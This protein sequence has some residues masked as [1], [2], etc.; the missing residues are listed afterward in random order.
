MP[1]IWDLIEAA[2]EGLWWVWWLWEWLW[3]WL[4][5]HKYEVDLGR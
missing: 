3:G 1:L 5:M 2:W 4:E